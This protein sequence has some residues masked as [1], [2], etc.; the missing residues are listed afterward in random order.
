MRSRLLVS[1]VLGSFAAL[2]GIDTNLFESK[3]YAQFGLPEKATPYRQAPGVV[4]EAER[5][6]LAEGFRAV[7][8]GQ[9][10]L[11]VDTGTHHALSGERVAQLPAGESGLARGTV[12]LPEKGDYRLWV[13][14]EH[15]PGTGSPFIVRV[16]QGSVRLE[17]TVGLPDAARYAP[18]ALEPKTRHPQ[19]ITA[20]GLYEEAFTLEGLGEGPATVELVAEAN[21]PADRNRQTARSV[22]LILLTR[23]LKD[24]WRA[25]HAKQ[26][27]Q[28]PILDLVRDLQ[29]A[30]WEARFRHQGDKAASPSATHLLT[31][32]PWGASTGP[33]LAKGADTAGQ[34]PPNQWSD[35]VAIPLKDTTGSGMTVFNGPD[36]T[37][38]VEIRPAGGGAVTRVEG[39]KSVRVF[40][41]PYPAW[42]EPPLAAETAQ[43][44]ALKALSEGKTPG[45][46]PSLP[47]VFGGNLPAGAEGAYGLNY[48]KL[49][50]ALGLVAWH[51]GNSGPQWRE[52]L[53]AAGA[54]EP[55][56]AGVAAQ[57][58]PP[59]ARNVE[60]AKLQLK[61]EGLLDQAA[62]YDHGDD[63]NLASWVRLYLEEEVSKARDKH[64]KQ[65]PEK[66]LNKL[67][68]EWLQKNRASARLQDYWVSQWGIFDRQRLKPDASAETARAHPALYLDSLAFYE[69]LVLPWL[70]EGAMRVR[71]QLGKNV[72]VGG[73][74]ATGPEGLLDPVALKLV[75]SKATD[76]VRPAGPSWRQGLYGSVASGLVDE[77]CRAILRGN[78]RGLLRAQIPATSPGGS[79]DDFLREAFTHLAHG[80][81]AID[82]A[83]V[84]MEET[85]PEQHIDHRDTSRFRA[86]RDLTHAIGFVEDILAE[87]TPAKSP[88]ALLLSETTLRWDVAGVSRERGEPAWGDALSVKPRTTY[89][90]D[91]QGMHATLTALG[92]CP[93]VVL[94]NE[95]GPNELAGRKL[96]IVTGDCLTDDLANRLEAWV[97][98]GGTVLATASAGRFDARRQPHKSFDKFLGLAKRVSAEQDSLVRSRWELP[99][100]T[101]VDAVAGP[102]WFLPALAVHERVEPAEG[103]EVVARFQ[104]DN[105]PAVC[106]R[107]LGEGK[108]ISVSALP[109]LAALWTASQPAE[110]PDLGARAATSPVRLDPGARH[111]LEETLNAAGV[112]PTVRVELEAGKHLVDTRLLVSDKGFALP[113]AHHG[114]T[115]TGPMTVRVRL[116][117]APA[118]VASAWHGDL[119]CDYAEG[120]AVI[121]LP[122]LGAVDLLR[123]EPG[124]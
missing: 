96:L 73:T 80:A 114:K 101:T 124:K 54:P 12:V 84:G 78:D 59:L 103:T 91:R 36:A 40:L 113:L 26:T 95:C 62:W 61:R 38:E 22:D 45:K 93:D 79:T 14:Y 90:L 41:P 19:T 7:R 30:R 106:L 4:L 33:L 102:S 2:A 111:L 25:Y 89:Q 58:N 69:D 3:A 97:R 123:I 1:T 20:M 8:M 50:K 117:K 34:L 53:K 100:L 107:R 23:D 49:H 56:S 31:R 120:E 21:G 32:Q 65:T 51:P 83:G 70:S 5:M 67:W 42:N 18:G 10:N 37:M 28:Y 57:D 77:D 17:K 85:Q 29:P 82:I 44:N 9:G 39:K 122:S 105:S 47:L 98:Q 74:L 68:V 13:R 66:L 55:Q 60:P 115:E 116:P 11:L 46:R 87:A 52:N 72:R 63:W 92:V 35:W 88:V 15:V 86:V 112:T 81:R 6:E 121:T 99:G 94:E 75:S 76:W 119:P 64:Q 16:T 104:S 24:A 118:K 110:T 108:V 27:P 48:A 43:E 109:G 71:R